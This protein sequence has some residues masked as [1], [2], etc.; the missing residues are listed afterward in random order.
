MDRIVDALISPRHTQLNSSRG[1]VRDLATNLG[2]SDS[3]FDSFSMDIVDTENE[4][5]VFMDMPG[6][7]KSSL[8]VDFRNNHLIVRGERKT[9][10]N[11]KTEAVQREIVYGK[12]MKEVV[13]PFSVTSRD[14]VSLTLENGVLK[15][16]VD[17]RKEGEHS[18]SVSFSDN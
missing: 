18:F 12:F 6:V 14:N 5:Q 8:N 10:Y 17:K 15:I 16:V 1:Y 9:P 3:W 7:E 2:L 11:E 4:T 13:L